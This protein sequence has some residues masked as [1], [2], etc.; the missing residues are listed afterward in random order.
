[1]P[2][3]HRFHASPAWL[4]GDRPEHGQEVEV[5]LAREP[6]EIARV[7]ERDLEVLFHETGLDEMAARTPELGPQG[8]DVGRFAEAAGRRAGDETA[9]RPERSLPRRTVHMPDEGAE[10][11][12]ELGEGRRVRVRGA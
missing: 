6:V 3:Q 4:R 11:V 1:M 7:S 2:V 10:L 12:R 9:Q 5:E 8:V